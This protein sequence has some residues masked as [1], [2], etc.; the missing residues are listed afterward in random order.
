MKRLFILATA[1]IV[2]LASCSKTQVV[3]TEA[4]EEIS[5]KQVTNV[6]TK[7]GALQTGVLGVF[8]HQDAAEYFGNTQFTWNTDAFK[9]NK[10]WPLEGTLD[11]TVYYPYSAEAEYNVNDNVLTVPATT[12]IDAVYYG[13]QR[14][15]DRDK[16]NNPAV[17]LNHVCAKITVNFDGGDLYNFSS[18]TIAGVNTAG[19]V[20]VDYGENPLT[21][22][23]V[24]PD[25]GS[26]TTGNITF[27]SSG[28]DNYVLPG[29]Q[30]D[31]SVTFT[32]KSGSATPIIRNA[33]VSGTWDAHKH[34]V[35]DISVT[36]NDMITFTATTV[37]WVSAGEP[38]T[39]QI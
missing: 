2:A 3:Y 16:N 20:E 28:A 7:A 35:Y 8:A 15:E 1:A 29:A 11:F 5:F 37:D 36:A 38:A 19:N 12:N 22:T 10:Q 18:A 6:M 27:A 33:T 34:Y 30:K 39:P 25:G 4:P 9:S 17:V 14:Y 32:Q 31:I 21:V 23:T 13:A 26:I 24:A